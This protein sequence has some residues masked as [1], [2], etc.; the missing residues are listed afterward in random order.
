MRLTLTP[1][2]LPLKFDHWSHKHPTPS[3]GGGPFGN[4]AY[5]AIA[6]GMMGARD[7]DLDGDSEEDEE[8]GWDEFYAS[9]QEDEE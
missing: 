3:K 6:M 2:S 1:D 5:F 7:D 9:E 4:N 8:I